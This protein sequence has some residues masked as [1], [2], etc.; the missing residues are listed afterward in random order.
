MNVLQ[1]DIIMVIIQNQESE[2]KRFHHNK[3]A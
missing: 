2:A 3:Q 1:G